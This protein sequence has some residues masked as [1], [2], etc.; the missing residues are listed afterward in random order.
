M[1]R[2]RNLLSATESA[3][4][5]A[6]KTHR[7]HLD[8]FEATL[9]AD[10]Q[11][12]AACAASRR[13]EVASRAAQEAVKPFELALEANRREYPHGYPA[14]SP[15]ADQVS[16]LIHTINHTR[17]KTFADHGFRPKPDP[18]TP[19]ELLKEVDAHDLEYLA[20]RIESVSG[21][22][23]GPDEI[24]TKEISR[25]WRLATTMCRDDVALPRLPVPALTARDRFYQVREWC[26]SV[27]GAGTGQKL[28][29]LEQQVV[30]TLRKYNRR[31]TGPELTRATWGGDRQRKQLL[32]SMVNKGV[33]TN[34]QDRLGKGYGLAEWP[35]G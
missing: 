24:W 27:T 7:A 11:F 1:T 13:W 20:D 31:M 22:R 9:K 6:V 3:V 29:A 26:R 19:E 4:A 10:P 25:W 18:R 15:I 32:A 33:L 17:A 8:E 21:Q 23:P 34:A 28:G 2:A 35:K 30:A 12:Q 14:G 5:I 16:A